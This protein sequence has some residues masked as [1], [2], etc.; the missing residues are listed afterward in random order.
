MITI[1]KTAVY[2]AGDFSFKNYVNLTETESRQILNWRN[3]E[4]IR[5]N[6]YNTAVIPWENHLAFIESL[7]E[8]T[9][10]FYWQVSESD[11]VCGSVNLVDVNHEIDQAELGYFMTPDQM[12][13]G[14]G[15]Y[16]IFN[17][18]EFAFDVLGLERLYGATN[19]ENR[20]AT[21]LDEYFGFKKIGEKTLV[22]DGTPV[23]FAEHILTKEDFEK[24]KS[25]KLDIERLLL[26]MRKN[27]KANKNV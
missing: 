22:I 20:S 12:G 15:F 5:K 21:L 9:D 17:T 4:S 19:V 7:K 2:K 13:G 11:A 3:D 1:D 26:F 24:D 23:Q 27:K 18:L 6:M 10:R 14:K 8:R 25:E 16:F